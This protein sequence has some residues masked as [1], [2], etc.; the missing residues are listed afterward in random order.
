VSEGFTGWAFRPPAAVG[1]VFVIAAGQARHYLVVSPKNASLSWLARCLGLVVYWFLATAQA[2]TLEYRASGGCATEADFIAA[3][4]ARGGHF[5]ALPA[6]E[7]GRVLSVSIGVE[8]GLFRGTLQERRGADAS[9]ARDVHGASCEEVV[10]ALAIVA[11]I[12]LRSPSAAPSNAEPKSVSP[13]TP[14][15]PPRPPLH[16]AGAKI[17]PVPFRTGQKLVA[18]E[19][20]TVRFGS[21]T[22]LTAFGGLAFGVVPGLTLPRLDITFSR[23]NFVTLPGETSYLVGPI[24]RLRSTLY[25][26]VERRAGEL[27]TSVGGQGIGVGPCYSPLYDAGGLELLFCLELG[28][29]FFGLRTKNASG[30]TV[31]DKTTGR[32]TLGLGTELTY[33]LGRHVQI[34]LKLGA[35]GATNP[36]SAERADG[37]RIFESSQFSGYSMLGIGGH[38]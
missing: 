38:F 5:S 37:G 25:P 8:S 9:V 22:N 7:A 20:G 17:W 36:I 2:Q 30:T 23:A 3:V 28:A 15:V 19:A 10:D 32:G 24:L 35:E 34:A 6:D 21:V 16:A 27:T 18:V 13:A 14:P 12:A 26:N 4:A 31:Q 11:A 33:N 29:E 1:V